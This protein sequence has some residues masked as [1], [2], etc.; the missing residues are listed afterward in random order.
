MSRLGDDKENKVSMRNRWW[1]WK[2]LRWNDS[3]APD[4]FYRPLGRSG[5][6]ASSVASAERPRHSRAEICCPSFSTPTT[7]P[8]AYCNP[9]EHW[10]R[11][12]FSIMRIIV[13]TVIQGIICLIIL[14]M[15]FKCFSIY[16]GLK[17]SLWIWILDR[18]CSFWI[19]ICEWTATHCKSQIS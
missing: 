10:R 16:N 13:S 1:Q 12:V 17:R 15:F 14:K 6:H 2:L 3:R 11:T 19:D 18:I 8:L 4:A 9:D 5:R 7:P